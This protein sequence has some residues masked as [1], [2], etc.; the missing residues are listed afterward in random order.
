MG[1]RDA[2]DIRAFVGLAFGAPQR[3]SKRER[4]ASGAPAICGGA[5]VL[6]TG[7]LGANVAG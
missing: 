1:R 2:G 6:V 4:F 7:Y 3:S 5:I